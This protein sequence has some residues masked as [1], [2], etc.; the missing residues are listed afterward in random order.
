MVSCREFF[1]HPKGTYMISQSTKTLCRKSLA[2]ELEHVEWNITYAKAKVA[3]HWEHS[4]K[5]SPINTAFHFESLNTWKNDLRKNR[6]YAA[7][8]RKSLKELK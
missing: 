1:I 8:L 4:D 3:Y 5:A 2:F 6:K 7:K